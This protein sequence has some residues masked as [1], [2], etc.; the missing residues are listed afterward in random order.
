MT[1]AE[2]VELGAVATSSGLSWV[3]VRP[4]RE[5]ESEREKR[6]TE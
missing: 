5:R 6:E 1:M 4:W 3:G 2:A